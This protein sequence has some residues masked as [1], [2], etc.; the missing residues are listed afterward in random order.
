[1][2]E[3]GGETS[4]EVTLRLAGTGKFLGG[5][6]NV[7][8]YSYTEGST[9][10]VPGDESGAI[11]DMSI[12][13]ENSNNASILLYKDEFYLQDRLHGAVIGTIENVAGNN[14]AITMGGRSRLAVLNLER[15]IQP[16][17]GSIQAVMAYLFGLVGITTEIIYETSL[18]T[19]VIRTP[20]F[21]GDVWNFTKNLASAHDFEV[22]VVRDYIVV[23]PVR[24]R[25]ISAEN[26]SNSSWQLQ[27]IE[28]AQSFDIAYY[29]YEPE[30][31]FLVEPKGGWV[32]ETTVYSVEAN[33][34]VDF[35]LDLEF[36]LTSVQQP[37]ARDTVAK[38]YGTASA[39]AVSGNDNL[40]V[41]AAFWNDFGGAMS[42]E[43][44]G[45]GNRV[46]VSITGPDYPSLSPYSISISDGASDYSTLRIVGT[47]MNYERLIYTEY[48]GLGDSD[49][50]TV[51]G[52]ELDNIATDTLADAKRQGL[53]ARR[54]YS[55][56][57][58]TFNT[59]SRE[60]KRLIGSVPTVLFPTFEDFNELVGASY[61][62]DNFNSDYSGVT[63]DGF[64]TALGNEVPQGFGEVSGSR[65]KLED[66]MYRVRTVS[67]T[68]D[69]VTIDAE[70]DTLFGDV[71]D[72]NAG[73]TFEEFNTIFDGIT[74]KDYALLPLRLEPIS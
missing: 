23:R 60:F 31:N 71:N 46:K 19:T 37:T 52:N 67:I 29:N 51:K 33:E 16:Q 20:G 36:Y 6:S 4:G 14:G 7:V 43:I 22:T 56:P 12:D 21:F 49:T 28:L 35:E 64:T 5:A 54:V 74:F 27:D 68:P 45:E 38:D 48:T 24:Q 66:A 1:M 62:F 30:S 15:T 11:G 70:Y 26:L 47:G 65:I 34:T 61:S 42:F 10:L 13:V 3:W 8:G 73:K 72:T 41:T 25:T 2:T 9:P 18:P 32:P 53:F 69:A 40:P 55:L 44:L 63:F 50:P 57:T 58:Q 59:S 17:S 39:Y